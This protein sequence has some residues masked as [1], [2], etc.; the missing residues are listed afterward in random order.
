MDHDTLQKLSKEAENLRAD[1]T[2]LEGEISG[3]SARLTALDLILRSYGY[4]SPPSHLEQPEGA[5]AGDVPY[6]DML[7]EF[8]RESLLI[9]P[10][11]NN[12]EFESWLKD[13][14]PNSELNSASI[15]TALR[16]LCDGIHIE[17]ISRGNKHRAAVY[18]IMQAPK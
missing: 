8:V 7:R 4:D 5:K 18:R 9:S 14:F 1:K 13:R 2:R 15:S 3:I 6:T 10:E 11:F 17:K 12:R 16:T